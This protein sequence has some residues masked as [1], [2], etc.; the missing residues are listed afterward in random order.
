MEHLQHSQKG[1]AASR[2]AAFY[3]AGCL[4]LGVMAISLGLLTSRGYGVP[5]IALF[6]LCIA[7]CWAAPRPFAL[8][9]VMLGVVVLPTPAIAIEKIHGVPLTTT[10]AF[11]TLC[12]ALT[13]WWHRRRQ[14]AH[15]SLS[16][17][18][19]TSL[20][21]L[22]I[23]AILQLG[24]SP[25]AEIKPIYQLSAFWLAGLL[26]G[27]MFAADPRMAKQVG[28]L[29]SPLA[30]FAIIE[31][32]VGR[33]NL[34]GNIVDAHL[35]EHL[36]M[37]GQALRATST[38]GHPLVAGAALVV[39]AFLVLTQPGRLRIFL[40][41]LIIAGAIATVSR[42]SLIGLGA[43]LLAHFVGTHRQRSQLIGTVIVT[44]LIV[45]LMIHFIPTLNTTFNSRILGASTQ[46][47]SIRLNSIKS[48]EDSI[49]RG[50]STLIT[51]R[52]LEGSQTYLA[53]TGGNLGFGT[54]DNQYV[55]SIYDDGLPAIIMVLILIVIGVIRARPGWRALAPLIASAATM[56]FFESL[57]WPVTGLLFW[58]AVGLATS[59][60]GPH[61]SD[62]KIRETSM[63]RHQA[64]LEYV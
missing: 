31:F 53:Q 58:L 44:S 46:T 49:S 59:P 35:F 29:A 4:S 30:I 56:F 3:L 19:L 28:L 13:L 42:S 40:F 60:G 20:L 51:G 38:F 41:S 36:T 26:L 37:N 14:G 55:T 47:Q 39:M 9:A 15:L 27:S 11:I 52:G 17:Y 48:L 63:K 25:Y 64:D 54:Y 43:G 12:A 21:L 23:V 57:Y 7:V 6:A 24:I 16:P 5:L 50:D 2:T 32:A 34:W 10:L 22:V 45:G 18:A 61:T 33:P 62:I 8:P 1:T